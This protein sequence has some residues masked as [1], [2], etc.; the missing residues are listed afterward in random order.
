MSRGLRT[1][2][3]AVSCILFAA[4]APQHTV[5]PLPNFVRVGLAPGDR[6]TV[7]TR[8]GETHEFVIAEI[9][10]DRLVGEGVQ[11][12]LSDIVSIKKHAWERPKS[13]CGGDAPLGC[14][15]PWI[16][17]LA[18][19]VHGHYKEKFYDAC[20]QHDYCYRHGFASYGFD[21]ESCD[22]AF[23]VDMQN[24]CP[25]PAT[26]G[27]GKFFEMLDDSEDSRQACETVANDYYQAVRRYGEERFLTA[28]ST[29]CEYDGPPARPSPAA[30]SANAQ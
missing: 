6:V 18:S 30:G 9:R 23:L 24:L 15:V 17:S 13:P 29:Y 20:A 1:L 7:M 28:Q 3:V 19:E 5:K 21:R 10:G 16:I 27:V 2:A 22:E 26:G 12:T 14:S 25:K 11:L 8:S 4:C